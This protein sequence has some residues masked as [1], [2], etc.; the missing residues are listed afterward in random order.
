M[1][2]IVLPDS[3]S[4]SW[5]IKLDKKFGATEEQVVHLR[6]SDIASVETMRNKTTM[7]KVE[8]SS[9]CDGSH[10]LLS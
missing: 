8:L 4:L 2:L 6:M 5:A 1:N 3:L 10:L 7:R 9:D